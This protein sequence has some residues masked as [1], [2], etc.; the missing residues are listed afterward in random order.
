MRDAKAGWLRV[1]VEGMTKLSSSSMSSSSSW[2]SSSS[3]CRVP[4]EGNSNRNWRGN[5]TDAEGRL[6]SKNFSS[7]VEISKYT[8][9]NSNEPKLLEGVWWCS[10]CAMS[11]L[12]TSQAS[13]TFG[14]VVDGYETSIDNVKRF[15]GGFGRNGKPPPQTIDTP[16]KRQHSQRSGIVLP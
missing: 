11:K 10:A 3:L 14:L 13:L 15:T 1:G 7:S 5:V 8:F 12:Q 2:S 6:T 9:G 4:K 16:T